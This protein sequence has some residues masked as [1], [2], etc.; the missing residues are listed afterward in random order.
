ML[1]PKIPPLEQNRLEDLWAL[2]ILDSPH[3]ERFDRLTR[4]A[5]RLFQVPIALVSL[6]DENR[7]WFKSHS[8]LDVTETPRN[9]SFCAHAIL[10]DDIFYIPDVKQDE[11]FL[12]NPMVLSKPFIRFYAGYPLASPQGGKLGTLCIIDDKPRQLSAADIDILRDLGRI[13]EREL[14]AGT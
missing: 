2:D 9:I 11:R 4:T 1:A 12:D 5:R 6:I 14:N 3:E 8:G 7:Q 13:A 10:G